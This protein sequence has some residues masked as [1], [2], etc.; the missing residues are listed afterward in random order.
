MPSGEYDYT[1]IVKFWRGAT[2]YT[3]Y[4]LVA[5]F[6]TMLTIRTAMTREINTRE[7]REK[8]RRY[9]WLC[10]AI[11]AMLLFVNLVFQ[12]TAYNNNNYI[13]NDW[14]NWSFTYGVPS[15]FGFLASAITYVALG[16]M[17]LKKTP[18][19]E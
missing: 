7:Y 11:L 17:S 1:P 5:S 6:S 19:I 16:H 15:F 9:A 8:S 14:F 13:L 18:T 4:A 3:S 2:H 10:V 12:Q